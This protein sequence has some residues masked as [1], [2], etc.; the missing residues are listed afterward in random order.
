MCDVNVN[1]SW[2]MQY[3]FVIF[4]CKYLQTHDEFSAYSIK[5]NMTCAS[6]WM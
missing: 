2:N 5:V 6:S 1:V 3:Q 4:S